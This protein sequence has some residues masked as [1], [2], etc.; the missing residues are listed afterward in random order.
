MVIQIMPQKIDISR[1]FFMKALIQTGSTANRTY[2][3]NG[4]FVVNSRLFL[5]GG[6]YGRLDRL[7]SNGGRPGPSNRFL[8]FDFT[9]TNSYLSDRT[10][11]TYRPG[12]ADYVPQSETS[13]VGRHHNIYALYN[14]KLYVFGGYVMKWNISTSYRDYTDTTSHFDVFDLGGF[15]QT[16]NSVQHE[17]ITFTYAENFKLGPW[18]DN[19]LE[20]FYGGASVVYDNCLYIVGGRGRKNGENSDEYYPYIFEYNFDLN[21]WT[22]YKKCNFPSSYEPEQWV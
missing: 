17:T 15:T 20:Y 5:V 14:G 7:S 16:S 12:G 21:Q 18:G 9:Q 2:M 11:T 22:R 19:A 6:Q 13:A 3:T 1:H 8:I 4:A 10:N